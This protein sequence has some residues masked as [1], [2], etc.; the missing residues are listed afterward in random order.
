MA[1]KAL[2]AAAVFEELILKA[3]ETRDLGDVKTRD[4]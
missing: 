2:G 3:G 1:G 4:Q